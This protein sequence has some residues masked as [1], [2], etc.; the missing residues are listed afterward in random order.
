VSNNDT[1]FALGL[2]LVAAWL[3]FFAVDPIA[4]RHVVKLTCDVAGFTGSDKYTC[5]KVSSVD[6]EFR[7]QINIPAQKVRI[8][9]YDLKGKKTGD[10]LLNCD[11]INGNN[12]DCKYLKLDTIDEYY[13][14]RDGYFYGTLVT[15]Y[16][17]TANY[18]GLTG[19]PYWLYHWG[20]FNLETA[21]KW[22]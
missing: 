12:W 13:Y 8:T 15:K 17:G 18:S 3:I 16:S 2:I 22:E 10:A 7:F 19:I 4:T 1:G 11:V 9:S 6:D 14:M 20:I 5:A 21:V